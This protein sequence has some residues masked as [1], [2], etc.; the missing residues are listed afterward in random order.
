MINVSKLDKELKAGGVPIDGCSSDGTIQYRTE[1]TA[2]Q[3]AQ[4]VAILAAHDPYDYAVERAK[5]YPSTSALVVALWEKIVEGRPEAADALQNQRL[6]VKAKWPKV[7]R[8]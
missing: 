2:E 4:A 8:Q 6:A 7:V 1:V 5:E 3:R